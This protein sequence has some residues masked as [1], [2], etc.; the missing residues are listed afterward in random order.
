MA[1]AG[2]FFLITTSTTWE[3][4]LQGYQI[5]LGP[6]LTVSIGLEQI[7]SLAY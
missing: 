5:G 3:G 6:I 1:L 2:A 7:T 4:L